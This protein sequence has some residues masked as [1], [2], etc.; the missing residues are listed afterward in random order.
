MLAFI[1]LARP[2]HATTVHR[3]VT[4]IH[5]HS[6]LCR[7]HLHLYHAGFHL[8][9]FHVHNYSHPYCHTT[10]YRFR[11]L[12]P[13][14]IV[15]LSSRTVFRSFYAAEFSTCL[16]PLPLRLLF[17]VHLVTPPGAIASLICQCVAF[18]Y[19]SSFLTLVSGLTGF[20]YTLSTRACMIK[21][22]WSSG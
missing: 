6:D 14:T 13:P 17:L 20:Q 1:H 16:L 12:P 7:K 19:M 18:W 8:I 2:S 11:S 22:G 3:P 4:I 21:V 9:S 5:L 10:L 15:Y